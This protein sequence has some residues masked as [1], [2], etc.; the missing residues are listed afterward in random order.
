MG[1]I[2]IFLRFEAEFQGKT[3]PIQSN[4][5]QQIGMLFTTS[6]AEPCHM[7]II[8]IKA[9]QSSSQPVSVKIRAEDLQRVYHKMKLCWLKDK[10]TA[11]PLCNDILFHSNDLLQALD[12]RH[13]C[14]FIKRTL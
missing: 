8:D 6:H 9:D 2:D 10:R 4:Q 3:V 13:T 1:S 11:I 14:F 7:H 12:S 5:D